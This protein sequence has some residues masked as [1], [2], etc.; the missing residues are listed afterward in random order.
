MS[1]E[2]RNGSWR[3]VVTYYVEGKKKRKVKAGF[4]TK[5]EALAYE[6]NLKAKLNDGYEID[7]TTML[8]TDFYDAWLNN[9]SLIHI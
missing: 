7:K 4:R 2:K 1:V 6:T 5:T 8:F 9:L 3:A